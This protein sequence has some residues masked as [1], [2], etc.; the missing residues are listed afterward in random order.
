MDGFVGRKYICELQFEAINCSPYKSKSKR[1][2]S[3][4]RE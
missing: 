4:K 2:T 1:W 3:T